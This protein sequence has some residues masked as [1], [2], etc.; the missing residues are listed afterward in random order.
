MGA[1]YRGRHAMLRRPTAIKLLNVDSPNEAAFARFER[2]VQ[3]TSQ[4]NH[5]NTVAVYDYGKTPEGIFYYAM[6]YLE[7]IDLA[8]LVEKYGTLSEARVIYILRQIL[9]F[10][11]RSARHR[12][13]SSRRKAIQRNF[14]SIRRDERCR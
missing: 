12:V 6:E 3:M 7:G 2:E 10:A 8:R 9:W 13:D 11:Q 4:L 1:V 14:V 5:P